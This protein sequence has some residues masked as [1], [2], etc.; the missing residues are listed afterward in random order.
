MSWLSVV[1]M[2][3]WYGT[4]AWWN[5]PKA[6][7]TPISVPRVPPRHSASNASSPAFSIRP[8]VDRFACPACIAVLS[9]VVFHLVP[10]ATRAFHDHDQDF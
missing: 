4:K 5:I 3:W 10:V 1:R 2:C 8:A 6:S 9:G 7:A